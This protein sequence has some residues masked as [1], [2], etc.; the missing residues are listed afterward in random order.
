MI[1]GKNQKLS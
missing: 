1:T